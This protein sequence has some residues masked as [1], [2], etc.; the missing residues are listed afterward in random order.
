MKTIIIKNQK[1][2][3]EIKKVK[4]DEEVI[5]K[6]NKIRIN[7]ILE[8]FGILR[9]EGEINCNKNDVLYVDT[10]VI[11]KHKKKTNNHH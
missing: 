3:D 8:V 11:N 5:F 1:Q 6:S 2:F 10:R 7:C 4:E 9:L